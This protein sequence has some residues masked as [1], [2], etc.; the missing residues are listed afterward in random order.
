MSTPAEFKCC[1]FR[2]RIAHNMPLLG[3]YGWRYGLGYVYEIY[4]EDLQKGNLEENKRA[5]VERI[6][7]T[8]P[9]NFGLSDYDDGAYFIVKVAYALAGDGARQDNVGYLLATDAEPS[10]SPAPCP[11]PQT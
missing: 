4:L 11:A 6:R 10:P 9:Q 8:F 2:C 1:G 3:S 7:M 5:V